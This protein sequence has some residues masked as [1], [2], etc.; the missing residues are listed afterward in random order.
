MICSVPSLERINVKVVNTAKSKIKIKTKENPSSI[1]VRILLKFNMYL[2][3]FF[4]ENLHHIFRIVKSFL[5]KT[6]VFVNLKLFK[7]KKLATPLNFGFN[8]VTTH[9]PNPKED[10][11]SCTLN[12]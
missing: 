3:F 12:L 11:T 9:T 6:Y 5:L 7:T 8:E 1:L 2:N 4:I 10:V